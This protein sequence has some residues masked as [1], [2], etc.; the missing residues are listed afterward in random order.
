MDLM[1]KFKRCPW[2]PVI[3][4]YF[5]I[6]KRAS[7][8]IGIY[9]NWTQFSE[10]ADDLELIDKNLYELSLSTPI[11]KGVTFAIVGHGFIKRVGHERSV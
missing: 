3:H 5:T 10:I 6:D 2:N 7:N 8:L 9:P 1:T 4:G 11:S